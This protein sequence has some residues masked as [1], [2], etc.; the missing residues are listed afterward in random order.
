MTGVALTLFVFPLL[1]AVAGE[2][3]PGK[4]RV[5]VLDQARGSF[6]A[7][8]R[9][10][11][12][13][14]ISLHGAPKPLLQ[15]KRLNLKEEDRKPLPVR[16]ADGP[17]Q[18]WAEPGFDD[19]RWPRALQTVGISTFSYFF[20]NDTPYGAWYSP[21]IAAEWHTICLRGTFLVTDPS[22]ARDLRFSANFHGGAAL[23]VNGKEMCRANLPAG[24]LA[25]DTLAEPY[26][27]ETYL[28]P[29]GQPFSRRD[30][31]DKQ[32]E[33]RRK[34]RC[35]VL[36]VSDGGA[37]G[38]FIPGA[39]LRAGVNVVALEVRTAPIRE[40][41]SSEGWTWTSMFPHARVW[42]ARLT[43]ATAEGVQ[44]NVGPGPG[45]A[46]ANSSPIETVEWWHYAQPSERLSPVRLVGAR[47]GAFSGKVVLSSAAAFQLT[48]AAGGR[49]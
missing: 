40:A 38:V 37:E 48:K 29:D 19:S 18:G 36:P 12:P 24:P 17:P 23:Y 42:D 34:L 14:L 20:C 27:K 32:F 26:P 15:A 45:I 28:R 22:K 10:R 7:F 47:N 13:T 11:T 43:A 30:E 33:D 9:W 31:G 44:S 25:A 1:T 2:R 35:R 39:L 3:A 41:F 49:C 21:G 16:A 8:L 6:R 5:V 4:E 46:I